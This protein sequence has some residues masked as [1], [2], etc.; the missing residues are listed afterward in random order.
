MFVAN[1]GGAATRR[2]IT[3]AAAPGR[4]ASRGELALEPDASPRAPTSP[5]PQPEPAR[6]RQQQR[7]RAKPRLRVVAPRSRAA[8]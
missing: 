3:N 1:K 5:A 6:A 4:A 2:R 7:R 8:T